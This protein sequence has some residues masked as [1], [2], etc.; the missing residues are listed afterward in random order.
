MNKIGLL[1]AP[2]K[3]RRL[4]GS[5]SL[6]F[7]WFWME[8]CAY[9]GGTTLPRCPRGPWFVR[10]DYIQLLKLVSLCLILFQVSREQTWQ[11]YPALEPVLATR[12]CVLAALTVRFF[13][14]ICQAEKERQGG[15]I[16]WG[17]LMDETPMSYNQVVRSIFLGLVSPNFK[18]GRHDGSIVKCRTRSLVICPANMLAIIWP[19]LDVASRSFS[20]PLLSKRTVFAKC[21]IEDTSKLRFLPPTSPANNFLR[22]WVDI[23]KLASSVRYAGS[24]FVLGIG[25]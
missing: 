20:I 18:V 14:A 3:P 1:Q 15:G 4:P 24:L 25:L 9:C 10:T 23:W 22:L 11:L 5:G 7:G 12:T 2:R 17:S 19:L 21:L 6:E 8:W 13:K 16:E